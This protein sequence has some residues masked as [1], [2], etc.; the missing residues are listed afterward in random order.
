MSSARTRPKDEETSI[1]SE[2][3]V[4]WERCES[5]RVRA[6]SGGRRVKNSGINLSKPE[7][8]T[9]EI[10]SKPKYGEGGGSQEN[11]GGRRAKS[12]VA[13]LI[14]LKEGKWKGEERG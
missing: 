1:S 7:C 3:I 5:R 13:E 2:S 10:R 6:S 14:N 11:P 8:Q 12:N 4:G 9:Q